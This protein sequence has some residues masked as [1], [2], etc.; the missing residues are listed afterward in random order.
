MTDEK[1]EKET[2]SVEQFLKDYDLDETEFC[3]KASK[4]IMSWYESHSDNNDRYDE[5]IKFTFSP[6]GQ[7]KDETKMLYD[8]D[9]KKPRLTLNIT[10]DYV[11][12]LLSLNRQNTPAMQIRASEETANSTEALET[13]EKNVS[14]VTKWL[15]TQ[16]YGTDAKRAYQIGFKTALTGGYGAF[17]IYTDYE[18]K[19]SFNQAIYLTALN[20]PKNSFFDPAAQEF[21]K[22]D[23]KFAGHHYEM[24]LDEFERVHPDVDIPQRFKTGKSGFK[25]GSR[26][27]GKEYITICRYSCKIPK[28]P[29]TIYLLT[30]DTK[31][32]TATSKEEAEQMIADRNKEIEEFTPPISFD[33]EGQGLTQEPQILQPLRIEDTRPVDDDYTIIEVEMI[34]GKVLKATKWGCNRMP[35]VYLDGNSYYDEDG[36]QVT[37]PLVVAAYDTQRMINYCIS[38]LAYAMHKA[39]QAKNIITK[40]QMGQYANKWTDAADRSNTLPYIN[41]PNVPPPYFKPP[42]PISP[43]FIQTYEIMVG[44]MSNIFGMY[45]SS[46]GQLPDNTS[47]IAV[48]R[49]ASQSIL[50]NFEYFDN[51]RRAQENIGKTFLA[52]K[53]TIF[54]TDRKVVLTGNDGSSETKSIYS[55]ESD[56]QLDG[57]FDVT[58]TSGASLAI[59]KQEAWEAMMRMFEQSPELKTLLM[60]LAVKNLDVADNPEMMKRIKENYID[61]RVIAEDQGIDP[62]EIPPSPQ[63]KAAAESAQL[64]NQI[65][66]SVVQVNQS[67]AFKNR[68][69]GMAAVRGAQ[70]EEDVAMQKGALENEKMKTEMDKASMELAGQVI[71]H[72]EPSNK[73]T[74]GK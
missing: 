51:L 33:G 30:D 19:I 68:A 36:E 23:G 39:Q 5:A 40:A 8:N 24:T 66:Q 6:D 65:K 44:N 13:A 59:Q 48:L 62:K 42:T 55:E 15:R 63:Q 38:S 73:Q 46:V 4:N 9:L 50:S 28:K 17:R 71:T 69:T 67:T 64:D 60:D 74:E 43:V 58:L 25:W 26:R 22:E 61:K 12:K 20:N 57:N 41:V 49:A 34:Q 11:N 29:Y 31:A 2:D 54:D 7:W 47:G 70:T 53:S 35:Y 37:M 52:L 72:T 45:K 21:C 18:S 14:F 3:E 1:N 56:N 16:A 10:K 27:N 32:H